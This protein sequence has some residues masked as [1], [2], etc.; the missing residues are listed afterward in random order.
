MMRLLTAPE[1]T[2]MPRVMPTDSAVVITKSTES[3]GLLVKRLNDS[4]RKP[5]IASRSSS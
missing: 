2:G 3:K 5:N 1:K 4:D